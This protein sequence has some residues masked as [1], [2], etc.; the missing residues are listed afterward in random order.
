[1]DDEIFVQQIKEI[2]GRAK[3]KQPEPKPHPKL[4][5]YKIKCS[6]CKK[7]STKKKPLAIV[8]TYDPCV[9]ELSNIY[10]WDYYCRRC[11]IKAG[12]DI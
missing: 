9:Y 5:D 8:W 7:E 10:R 3:E 12:E 1:M 11:Y 2:N 6:F 4:L